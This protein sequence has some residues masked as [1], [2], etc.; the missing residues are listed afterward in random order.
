MDF[1]EFV[2]PKIVKYADTYI[3]IKRYSSNF[4]KE[5]EYVFYNANNN[6]TL[7]NQVILASINADDTP[8]DVNK[9]IKIVSC[10]INQYIMN[11]VVNFKTVDYSSIKNSMFNLSKRIRNLRISDLTLVLLNE[12]KELK[13]QHNLN[14]LLK[15]YLNGF[16]KRYM[17]HILSRLTYIL[18]KIAK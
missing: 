14:G 2:L 6:F 4:D 8:D 7:Q 3:R 11:R 15:F 13:D 16:S 1:G 5:Y 18:N 9:K 10:F 12:I 17:L